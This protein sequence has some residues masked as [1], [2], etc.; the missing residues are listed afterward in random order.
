MKFEIFFVRHGVSCANQSKKLRGIPGVHT[1]YPDPELTKKGKEI[2]V[3][4][5]TKLQENINSKWKEKEWTIG[6]SPMIRAQQT[7]YLMLAK[8]SG[9]KITVMPHVNETGITADNNAI[10]KEKQKII[11]NMTTPGILSNLGAD[12]RDKQTLFNR[13]N[14]MKFKQ[15]ISK[16]GLQYFGKNKD[17]V[18]RSVIFTHGHYLKLI[19]KK[20]IKNIEFKNNDAIFFKLDTEKTGPD[21]I[22]NI[23]TNFINDYNDMEAFEC[24]DECRKYTGCTKTRKTIINKNKNKNKN[25]TKNI[26]TRKILRTYGNTSNNDL[27]SLL[28]STFLI[29]LPFTRII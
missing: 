3:K 14:F 24:P 22:T 1:F 7:A 17:N 9:K 26:K 2:A 28:S 27:E 25:K 11:M 20:Y 6:S 15:W 19:F 23:E 4:L 16:G 10:N 18:Y 29:G 21:H 12:E 8:D 5:S 13:S